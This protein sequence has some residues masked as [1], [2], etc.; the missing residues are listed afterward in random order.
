MATNLVKKMDK[1][2]TFYV[3][4]VVEDSI[5]KLVE[6]EE[7]RVIACGSSKE[8]ADKSVCEQRLLS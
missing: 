4:D 8:V 3:F 2:T 6:V 5:K 7:G 1:S